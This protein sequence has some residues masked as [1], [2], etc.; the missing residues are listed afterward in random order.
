VSLVPANLITA[1]TVP[2]ILAGT[3]GAKIIAMIANGSVA[4]WI[5]GGGTVQGYAV[6]PATGATGTA[7]TITAGKITIVPGT[8]SASL[9]TEFGLVLWAGLSLPNIITTIAIC[10]SY[11]NANNTYGIS[12]PPILWTGPPSIS[13]GSF[14]VAPGGFISTPS[15]ISACYAAAATAAGLIPT[16]PGMVI[17]ISVLTKAFIAAMNSASA[18]GT[19]AGGIPD[20]LTGGSQQIIPIY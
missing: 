3:D 18:V 15:G 16:N 5:G 10:E 12:V 9:T 1:L 19:I 7:G 2:A 8:W 14:A 4:A 17:L 20:G 13:N 6:V 11:F